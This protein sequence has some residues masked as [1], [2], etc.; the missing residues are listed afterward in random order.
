MSFH[1]ISNESGNQNVVKMYSI[2][3]FCTWTHSLWF[4]M[5]YCDPEL[6]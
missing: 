6:Q 2:V 4:E 3:V 5:I 1:C